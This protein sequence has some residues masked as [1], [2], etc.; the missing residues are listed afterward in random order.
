[1][2]WAKDLD[3]RIELHPVELAGRGK[4]RGEAPF[5][6]FLDVIN[7]V[8][9]YIT[10][11]IAEEEVPYILFGHSMGAIIAYEL[12]LRLS[13]GKFAKRLSGLI[14]SGKN[15][16]HFIE[17]IVHSTKTEGF[18]EDLLD[19]G[20][21][22]KELEPVFQLFTPLINADLSLLQTY[23]V[24]KNTLGCPLH[25]FFGTEDKL[26]K[27]DEV[28]QWQYYCKEKD[29]FKLYSFKGGHFFIQEVN[30]MVINVINSIACS[31]IID[32]GVKSDELSKLNK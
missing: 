11:R 16:P 27:E 2:K 10:T 31:A 7:D 8:I 32:F 18:K 21:F 15:A 28:K 1:M 6:Q 19:L 5:T 22:P 4:R 26:M 30:V 29:D 25:A 12:A 17:P 23:K 20:G 3:P 14:V 24:Q 13:Q 9:P